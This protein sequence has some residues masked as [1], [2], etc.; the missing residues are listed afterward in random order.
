MGQ[1][2]SPREDKEKTNKGMR[3][4]DSGGSSNEDQGGILEK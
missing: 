2:F 4:S 3:F 1:A